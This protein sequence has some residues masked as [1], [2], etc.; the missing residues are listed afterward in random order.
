MPFYGKMTKRPT[1]DRQSDSGN[2]PE[3]MVVFVACVDKKP[4]A[5][6]AS[7][8]SGIALLSSLQAKHKLAA[9]RL[10]LLPFEV[11]P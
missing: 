2:T 7:R 1:K 4:V 8:E 6:L 10:Q 9:D 3:D 5:C 11:M